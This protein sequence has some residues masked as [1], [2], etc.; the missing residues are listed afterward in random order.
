MHWYRLKQRHEL[1]RF[2]RQFGSDLDLMMV[3]R[4][5]AWRLM[6]RT[7]LSP[8]EEKNAREYHAAVEAFY[9]AYR[10]FMDAVYGRDD[11][12]RQ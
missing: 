1:W 11:G 8:E 9:Q 5:R 12:E 2:Q 6:Q 10:R 7:D 3:R 4:H